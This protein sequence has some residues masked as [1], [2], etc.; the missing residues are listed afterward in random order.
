MKTIGYRIALLLGTLLLTHCASLSPS[1]TQSSFAE[2]DLY[3]PLDLEGLKQHE[4]AV[5]ARRRAPLDKYVADILAESKDKTPAKVSNPYRSILAD[6]F[7][8]AY[9][10]RLRGSESPTYHMPSSYSMATTSQSFVYATAYDPAQY[11]IIISGDEVWVEPKYITSMFGTWGGTPYGYTAY[12]YHYA[13]YFNPYFNFG[14]GWGGYYP[15]WGDPFRGSPWW[16]FTESWY[17]SGFYH[18]WWGWGWGG[19][20]WGCGYYAPRNHRYD[21]YTGYGTGSGYR[22]NPYYNRREGSHRDNYYNRGGS[23]NRR[24]NGYNRHNGYNNRYNNPNRYDNRNNRHDN[25]SYS[26]PSRN[27]EQQ[28]RPSYNNNS[29]GGGYRNTGGGNRYNRGR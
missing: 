4:E 25:D 6:D 8:T 12:Y 28:L 10:R 5:A 11:N 26:R 9:E 3:S 23:Y 22:H 1:H 19:F 29:T 17:Y 18:P 13:P 16:G 15:Y 2:D 14:Y 21:S 7:E 24:Q 27:N 20:G